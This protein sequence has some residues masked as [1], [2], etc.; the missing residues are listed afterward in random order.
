MQDIKEKDNETTECGRKLKKM[1]KSIRRKN[2]IKNI[3][4]NKIVFF[5]LMYIYA[6]EK[7]KVPNEGVRKNYTNVEQ[8]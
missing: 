2:I 5:F 7:R 6:R 1:I 8:K 4:K 3:I